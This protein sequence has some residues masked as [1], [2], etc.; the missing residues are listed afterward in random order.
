MKRVILIILTFNFSNSF[1]LDKAYSA[2]EIKD[3]DIKEKSKKCESYLCLTKSDDG[4]RVEALFVDK[5]KAPTSVLFSIECSG[6]LC[7]KTKSLRPTRYNG[8]NADQYFI[9]K[10][11]QIYMASKQKDQYV[12]A[13][14]INSEP[15][16]RGGQLAGA[17][18]EWQVTVHPIE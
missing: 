2:P 7:F 17:T 13:I 1:A 10:Q 14:T 5:F 11:A 8:Y 16:S 4:K 3:K 12:A 6:C 15:P 18:E 9:L